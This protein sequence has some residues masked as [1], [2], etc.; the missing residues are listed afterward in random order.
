[1]ARRPSIIDAGPLHEDPRH[2]VVERLA[3]EKTGRDC[4]F[5]G[6]VNVADLT[7]DSDFGEPSWKDQTYPFGEVAKRG[8]MTNS[9]VL[10]M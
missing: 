10:P 4:E 2:S 3:V 6:M 7:R 9:P 8:E 1:M 5:T